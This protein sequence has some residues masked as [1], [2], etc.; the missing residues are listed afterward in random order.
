MMRCRRDGRVL[1]AGKNQTIK[2]PRPRSIWETPADLG[3]WTSM[4]MNLVGCPS[5]ERKFRWLIS[6]FWGRKGGR[7]SAV[8]KF[9]VKTVFIWVSLPPSLSPFVRLDLRGQSTAVPLSPR[10][11]NA[12]GQFVSVCDLPGNTQDKTLPP[13]RFREQPFRGK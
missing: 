8:I 9:G 1:S 3:A 12:T 11:K 10:G 2:P 7:S 6:T 5:K 13:T 4:G